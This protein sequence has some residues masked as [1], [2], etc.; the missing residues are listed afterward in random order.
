MAKT[1]QQKQ[2]LVESYTEKLSRSKAVVFAD[3][4]GLKMSQ[5]SNLRNKLRDQAA[6]FT[7]TKNTLL[8]LALQKVKLPLPKQEV[9]KGPL[10]TLFSYEDDVS[11]IKTL[12]KTFQDAQIGQLKGGILDAEL[13]D[14]FTITR[15]ANLPTKEELRAKIIGSLASPLYE[16]VGVLQANLRNLV[17]V[18][19][20]IKQQRG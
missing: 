14:A 17:F 8:Q 4:K 7:I 3:F 13:L 10:A 6:E 5:L 19:D 18:L 15:L 12:V 11:P 16:M 9:L 2:Q 1:K 20:Q